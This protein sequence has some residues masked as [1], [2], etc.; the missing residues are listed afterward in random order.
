MLEDDFRLLC[1][2]SSTAFE[3][4]FVAGKEIVPTL[5]CGEGGR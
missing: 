2:H 3:A 5:T 4:F 1:S